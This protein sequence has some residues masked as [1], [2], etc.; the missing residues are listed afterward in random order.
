[1][2][3]RI[4]GL[5]ALAILV[6]ATSSADEAVPTFTREQ[7]LAYLE[8][9]R[10][11]I[12]ADNL[13]HAATMHDPELVAALLAAGIDADARGIMPQS[14]LNL[15]A[16]TGCSLPT[17]DLAKQLQVVEL[18][19]DAGADPNDPSFG[20][21][22]MIVFVA[23]QCPREVVARI[24]DAGANIEARS[25]QGFSPLSMALVAKNYGAAELLIERGARLKPETVAKLFA[26]PETPEL[27]ALVAR[28]RKP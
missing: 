17:H 5:L 9:K 7:A 19:L 12:S 27:A 1:V 11:A 25:P 13:S 18:L 23:Q 26:Q 2:S 22:P 4:R 8:E 28:A 14:A 3:A 15:A 24:I 10:L 20:N 16:T 21:T 6:A